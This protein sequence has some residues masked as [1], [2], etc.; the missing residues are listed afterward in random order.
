MVWMVLVVVDA[1][2]ALAELLHQRPRGVSAGN[3][4]RKAPV[5]AAWWGLP[6]PLRLRQPL[7]S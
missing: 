6:R 2:L 4:R 3:L 7:A 1:G 5:A